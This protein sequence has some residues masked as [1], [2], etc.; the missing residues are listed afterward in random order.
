MSRRKGKKGEIELVALLRPLF[1]MA[2]RGLSQS[3]GG[4]EG[5]DIEGC[6]PFHLESKRQ[7]RPNIPAALQQ[8]VADMAAAGDSSMRWPVAVTQ[9]DRAEKLVTMRLADWLELVG[10]ML[11]Y[12]RAVIERAKQDASREPGT[13][14]PKD[15]EAA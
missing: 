8:A 7:K 4:K 10:L 1:P 2:R 5:P 15:P 9:A 3:R 13:P 11:R 6:A 12:E 14:A